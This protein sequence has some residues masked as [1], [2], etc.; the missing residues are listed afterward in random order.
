MKF[1]CKKKNSLIFFLFIFLFI[2]EVFAKRSLIKNKYKLKNFIHSTR[3]MSSI[4]IINYDI[5]KD[6]KIDRI[7]KWSNQQLIHEAIDKNFDGIFEK[8]TSFFIRKIKFKIVEQDLNG[9]GHI[10][11]VDE[12][13]LS[14]K[15]LIK[16]E[17]YRIEDEEKILLD[18]FH[19]SYNQNNNLCPREVLAG[20]EQ[21]EILNTTFEN[22][23]VDLSKDIVD[24]GFG[25]QVTK[26]CF[27]KWGTDAFKD[28]ILGGIQTG[29]ACLQDLHEEILADSE[30]ESESESESDKV[31]LTSPLN[32]L[33][34]YQSLV[35][36]SK[37][38]IT[39]EETSYNWTTS[40]AGH[41]SVNPEG[42]TMDG[43]F[44]HP[45]ISI[46]PNHPASEP[47]VSSSERKNLQRTLFHEQL[48]NLGYRH[49]EGIEYP[50]ACEDCCF[51]DEGE[52]DHL[53]IQELSCR[54]CS[55]EYEEDSSD[56]NYISDVTF[57]ADYTYRDT[58]LI[59][60][61]LRYARVNPKNLNAISMI[62]HASS[63]FY[64]PLGKQIAKRIRSSHNNLP[65][66]AIKHLSR[67]DNKLLTR[68]GEELSEKITPI[69]DAFYELYYNHDS[70]KALKILIDKKD[71]IK[72]LFN[73]ATDEDTAKVISEV[74]NQL[75]KLL[76][77]LWLNKFKLETME[78]GSD[79]SLVADELCITL[80]EGN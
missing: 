45:F 72:T 14:S 23:N 6:K 37:V 3:V 79:T 66:I 65:A 13:L 15:D 11:H 12:Y 80:I 43:K 20:V 27:E 30:S 16:V 32:L 39:C 35:E 75:K 77:D 62:A 63:N 24:I 61:S 34:A 7:E 10:D 49:G 21:L 33:I 5:N 2:D 74:K 46:N 8:K 41:A 44:N 73:S 26:S 29:L 38:S 50:Y 51:P 17:K 25:Y 71:Q 78:D 31:H 48:H 60:N 22:I 57:Y 53:R 59:K 1:T 58:T 54:I 42:K 69:S 76:Y 19:L 36:N 52:N 4:K 64:S 68:K 9:D 70:K 28:D 67:V 40:F 18:R 55:G 47:P 56:L